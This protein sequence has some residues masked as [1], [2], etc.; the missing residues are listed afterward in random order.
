MIYTLPS[1]NSKVTRQLA[2]T[3]NGFVATPQELMSTI[4]VKR[5]PGQYYDIH[6]SSISSVLTP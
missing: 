3:V 2:L 5:L 6:H 1:V 4:G